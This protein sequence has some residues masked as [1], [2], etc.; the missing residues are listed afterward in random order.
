MKIKIILTEDVERLGKEGEIKEVSAGYFRNFLIPRHLAVEATPANLKELEIKKKS[1]K[2]K[3]EKKTEE[4]QHLKEKLEGIILTVFK[5][6]GEEG[7]IFG[8]VT[9]EEIHS[10]LKEKYNIEIEK[11]KIDIP[12]NIR[13]VGIHKINLRL[14]PEIES[15][16]EI[17]I[18]PE[19][20]KEET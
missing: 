11:R 18:Q 5:K 9:K 17:N 2:K 13:S 19:E 1:L 7:K 12:P 8:S 16:I 3:G 20:E 10:I 14:S 6:V 4:Y 15:E